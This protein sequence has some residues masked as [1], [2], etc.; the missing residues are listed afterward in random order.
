MSGT[1]HTWVIPRELHSS[2]RSFSRGCVCPGAAPPVVGCEARFGDDDSMPVR[3][4]SRA[5]L[6]GQQL[7]DQPRLFRTIRSRKLCCHSEWQLS[8]G[9]GRQPK[10]R[11]NARNQTCG[12]I[13]PSW[14]ADRIN[15]S[16]SMILSQPVSWSNKVGLGTA[17]FK[18]FSPWTLATYCGHVT[19]WSRAWAKCIRSVCQIWSDSG[20]SR[21]LSM[22]SAQVSASGGAASAQSKRLLM[23]KASCRRRIHLHIK[24]HFLQLGA[25]PVPAPLRQCWT[26]F[27]QDF[28]FVIFGKSNTFCSI[29]SN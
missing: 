24:S 26:F 23:T 28:L 6:L 14:T 9:L 5:S 2:I 21:E 3:L 11:K 20:L 19:S 27:V 8:S 17:A 12:C 25:A 22:T 1:R 10:L 15:E 7:L 13:Q 16:M 29:L 18:C 4:L